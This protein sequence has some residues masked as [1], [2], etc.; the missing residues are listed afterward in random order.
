M[1]VN[2]LHGVETIEIQAGVRPIKAVKTAV[3]GLIGTDYR[4]PLNSVTVIRNEQDS[5]EKA[6][7]Y[8]PDDDYS[9]P[10]ALKYIF[11][12]G[13]ATVLVVNVFDKDNMTTAVTNE[14]HA[15]TNRKFTLNYQP[16][17]DVVV[18]NVA[19]TTTYVEGTDY[20]IGDDGRTITIINTALA[21]GTTLHSDY[22]RGDL[23]QVGT[24]E[25]IGDS[26]DRTG[27]YALRN[28]FTSFGFSPKILIAPEWSQEVTVAVVLDS[29]AAYHRG[30]ALID[31]SETVV[32]DAI[33]ARGNAASEFGMNSQRSFLLFPLISTVTPAGDNFDYY[34]SA[35]MA[36]VI[37][38][39]DNEQGYWVSPSNQVI[40]QAL[41]VSTPVSWQINRADTDANALN[42]AGIT[43]AVNGFGTGM[44]TWGNRN[45]SFPVN[46]DAYTFLSVRRTADVLHESLELASLQFIDK[47][48]TQALIDAIRDSAN[49]FIR[50]LIGRG[51]LVDGEC[52]YDPADNPS[53]ELALGHL[54]FRLEFMPPPPCE[55]LTF[56]SFLDI[57]KLKFK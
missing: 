6:G 37:C 4:L 42:E 29:E 54:T 38:R 26:G 14:A 40:R 16:M 21:N 8:N 28:A 45:A 24:T 34:Y 9:I 5:A 30:V 15:I 1:A 44:L 57:S 39:V 55:R 11:A 19:G 53:A 51:A 17:G 31:S 33:T 56:K 48:I 22:D 50:T 23:T 18:T 36:G 32:D 49:A 43:T 52:I 7:V 46:S 41:G 2:F 12:Q 10:K 13:A 47:P 20:T 25:I 35:F 3:V 27:I